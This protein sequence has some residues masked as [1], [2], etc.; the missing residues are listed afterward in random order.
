MSGR[1]ERGMATVELA[2]VT[3]LVAAVVGLV[4]WLG[5]QLLVL[6]RC[7]VVAHQVARQAARTDD[8]AAR[9]AAAEAPP[10]AEVRVSEAGGATTVIVRFAPVLFGAQL[11]SLEASATV[12]DEAK[13]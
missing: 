10:G 6:D 11:G 4:G 13:P 9:R 2:G 1:N 8:A 3:V 7:Q 12:L 5:L